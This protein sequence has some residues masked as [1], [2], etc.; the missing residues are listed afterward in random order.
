M[1]KYRKLAAAVATSVMVSVGATAALAQDYTITVWAGGSGPNDNYRVDAIKIAADFL[2]REAAIRGD[3][4]NITIDGRSYDGWEEFKQGVTLAAESGNA[5]NIVVT[6]HE[7]IAPWAQSGLIVP[8]EDYLDLDAWPINDIYENLIEIASYNG[9]V[10]GLPQDAESRPFFF[11]KDHLRGIG[12][13]D[14]DIDA[15]PARVAAGDYTLQNVLED[16]KKIQ[17]AGL[18]EAGYGFY[19]RVSNGPDYW[20]FY[21]SFGGQ[22]EDPDSG[23][24]VL[25]EAI[26]IRFS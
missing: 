26:S 25:Y 5:P 24:L 2:E 23:K 11:W 8:I 12:Y 14:A 13:S 10:Y 18:V 21:L 20:Q 9:M 6:G 22:I 17:D 7:D 16:A 15:L 1:Q 4:L 3:T 19:P